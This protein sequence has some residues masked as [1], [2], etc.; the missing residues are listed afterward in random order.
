M[1]Y[2]TEEN[3]QAFLTVAQVALRLGLSERRIYQLIDKR[4]LPAVRLGRSVR[5]PRRAWDAWLENQE[6]LALAAVQEQRRR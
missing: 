1:L 2:E 5:V 4:L 6:A 3:F